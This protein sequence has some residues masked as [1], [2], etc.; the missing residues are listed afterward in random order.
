[1]SARVPCHTSVLLAMMSYWIPIS[2]CHKC[3]GN[4]IGKENYPRRKMSL[5]NS[6]RFR[7]RGG[8]CHDFVTLE[9]R[10]SCYDSR[11]SSCRWWSRIVLFL[12]LVL[13]LSHVY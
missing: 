6:F 5:P 2:E 11:A 4:A 7:E 9:S 8:N 3:Y 10:F 13:D 12:H 1:M